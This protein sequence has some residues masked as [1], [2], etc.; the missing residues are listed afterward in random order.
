MNCQPAPEITCGTTI[1]D[2]CVNISGTWPA[3][4]PT[5]VGPCYRQSDWNL[6]ASNLLCTLANAV[7]GP[8]PITIPIVL[9]TG[10]TSILSSMTLTGLTGCTTPPITLTPIKTT[11][12]AEFQNI[13]DILCANLPV[14]LNTPL[15]LGAAPGLNLKCL[16]DPCG[17]PIATLGGLLQA[18]INAE[19]G[20]QVQTY[21]ATITQTGASAPVATV[22]QNTFTVSGITLTWARTGAGVYTLTATGGTPFTANKTTL[23]VGSVAP[24]AFSFTRTSTTVIA[25][26]SGGVDGQFLET[27]VEIKVYP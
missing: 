23:L 27:T 3:C 19:C 20:T 9:P 7:A 2:A 1:F 17:V 21:T 16:Q 13:Y 8:N 14:S 6:A 4:F 24:A 10:V 15:V 12:A 18:L 25:L 26:T 22:L 11:V 5:G